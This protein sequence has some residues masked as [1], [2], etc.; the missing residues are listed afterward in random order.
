MERTDLRK[1]MAGFGI[2]ALLAGVAV[3]GCSNTQKSS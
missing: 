3:A 1:V 2:A